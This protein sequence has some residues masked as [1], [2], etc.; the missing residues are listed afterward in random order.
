[1]FEK[2]VKKCTLHLKIQTLTLFLYCYSIHE[3]SVYFPF[4]HIIKF[5]YKYWGVRWGGEGG[6][7]DLFNALENIKGSDLTKG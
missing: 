1:M 7:S 4:E 3:L 6:G 2:E 5:Y